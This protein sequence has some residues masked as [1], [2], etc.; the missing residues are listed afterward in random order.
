MKEH[1]VK[2]ILPSFSE[3]KMLF[4]SL[5]DKTIREIRKTK[6]PY[7]VD[8]NHTQVGTTFG[9]KLSNS[10][11]KIFEKGFE[12]VIVL[13]TD[14][15]DI[16]VELIQAAKFKLEKQKCIVGPSDDGGTYLIGFEKSVFNQAEFSALSWESETIC[17]QVMETL[18][19]TSLTCILSDIDSIDDWRAY[20][21]TSVQ[22]TFVSQLLLQFKKAFN[23][24]QYRA[25]F[26]QNYFISFHSLR[27]PPQAA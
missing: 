26:S 17:S 20:I 1:C 5:F 22:N 12:K 21:T 16:S 14:S 13:G 2:K 23:L 3:N 9:E 10:V 24:K 15:P 11:Q 7:F 19:G 4:K 27:G 25:F 8:T 6:L 18:K